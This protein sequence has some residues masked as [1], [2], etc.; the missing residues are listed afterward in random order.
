MRWLRKAVIRWLGLTMD[1]ISGEVPAGRIAGY[2]TGSQIAAGAITSSHVA[3]FFPSRSTARPG[4]SAGPR[5]A[6]RTLSREAVLALQLR[7]WL[8]RTARWSAK[9]ASALAARSGV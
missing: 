2:V 4:P 1:D 3:A 8:G 6:S 7:F 5:A 9:F